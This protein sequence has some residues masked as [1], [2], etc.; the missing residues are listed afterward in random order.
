MPF[1]Y[2]WEHPGPWV[3]PDAFP[4]LGG[5]AAMREFMTKSKERGWSP[6]LYGDSLCWVTWQG[7]T[8]Y[9]GMPYFRSH[10]GEAAVARRPDGTFVEDVWPWRKNYWACVGTEKGRQMILE[11][12][13]KMA[14][15]GPSVV[16]QFDQGPGPMACYATD[17]GHPPVPGPWMTE[18]FKS[19]L[20]ADAETARSVNPGLRCRA[21]ELRRR[22]TFRIFKYGMAG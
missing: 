12:T 6:F 21:R 8:G 14:E 16:Q 1:V 18:N 19:L 15:L 10:G 11:M 13:R 9:D 3:Q 5:E 7:N 22:S 4:P 2:N 17:H 20:K